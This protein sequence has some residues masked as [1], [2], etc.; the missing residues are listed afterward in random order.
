LYATFGLIFNSLFPLVEAVENDSAD[1][2]E[3]FNIAFLN[4]MNDYHNLGSIISIPII[5]LI[6]YLSLRKYNN[7]YAEHLVFQCYIMS[8]IGFIGFIVQLI[9]VNILKMAPS[10]F[11]GIYTMILMLYGN[12]VFIAKYK[13][14]FK[15][16]LIANFK[17]WLF[18]I[19]FSILIL[20]V[21]WAIAML[22]FNDN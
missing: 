13:L 1:I 8:F 6:S 10:N 18:L 16:T 11:S 21:I 20:V 9:L 22:I 7:N 17:F 4:I 12:Y 19:I 5:A 3:Q 2:R 14:N 15:S